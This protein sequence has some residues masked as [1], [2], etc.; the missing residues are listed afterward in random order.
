MIESFTHFTPDVKLKTKYK[1]EALI[2]LI[3]SWFFFG[4]PALIPSIFSPDFRTIGL[5]IIG[6]MFIFFGIIYLIAAFGI[7]KYFNTMVYE[8]VEGEIHVS[9]GLITKTRKIVPYRTITNIEIKRGPFDRWFGIGTIDIQTAG[10]SA[11]R[12]GPEEKMEGVPQEQLAELQ[13]LLVDRVRKIRGT[14]GLTQDDDEDIKPTTDDMGILLNE[15]KQI[16]SILQT[17]ADKE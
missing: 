4:F 3:I 16:K 2:I 12:M 13:R 9:K 17:I 11:G 1:V 15:V 8:V 14:P 6:S 10:F 7:T 5:I